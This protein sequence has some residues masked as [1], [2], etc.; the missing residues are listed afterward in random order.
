M[1]GNL[2]NSTKTCMSHFRPVALMS[3]GGLG[4]LTA[5]KPLSSL[6]YCPIVQTYCANSFGLAV[7]TDG[8][9]HVC[10]YTNA[11]LK[12]HELEPWPQNGSRTSRKQWHGTTGWWQESDGRWALLSSCRQCL[13]SIF[14]SQRCNYT[15]STRIIQITTEPQKDPP[16]L[17]PIRLNQLEKSF[18]CK[19]LTDLQ[20]EL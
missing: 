18:K 15:N 3:T 14:T 19:T 2:I 6:T 16:Q 20:M 5:F 9:M 1:W 7:K 4:W 12:L 8:I 11:F 10:M 17:L 13:W